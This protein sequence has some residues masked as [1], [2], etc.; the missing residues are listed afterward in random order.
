VDDN[1]N[2]ASSSNAVVVQ[3]DANGG[4]AIVRF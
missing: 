2:E 3:V 1:D 4:W